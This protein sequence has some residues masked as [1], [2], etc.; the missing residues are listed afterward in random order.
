MH[1][2][3]SKTIAREAEV[4]V[5]KHWQKNVEPCVSLGSWSMELQNPPDQRSQTTTT[6]RPRSRRGKGLK[7]QNE[8]SYNL[9]VAT[10]KSREVLVR[11]RPVPK[12]LWLVVA[13]KESSR[14]GL[15]ETNVVQP[16]TRASHRHRIAV[17]SIRRRHGQ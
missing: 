8:K 10:D 9:V 17:D 13:K 12:R 15:I 4:E 5:K 11:N 3:E 16:G 6:S 2:G 7:K 1:E 14:V